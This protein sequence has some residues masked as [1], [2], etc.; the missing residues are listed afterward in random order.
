MLS[1]RQIDG[2]LDRPKTFLL[3]GGTEIRAEKGERLGLTIQFIKNLRGNIFGPKTK[4]RPKQ[5]I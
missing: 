2:N 3:G 4:R 1:N 5:N